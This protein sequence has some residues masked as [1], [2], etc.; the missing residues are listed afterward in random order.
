MDFKN[1]DKKTKINNKKNITK[2]RNNVKIKKITPR[3]VSQT[4]K[5]YK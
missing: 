4:K 1:I 2:L 5:Q 3:R